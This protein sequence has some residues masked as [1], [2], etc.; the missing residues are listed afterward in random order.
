MEEKRESENG[1]KKFFWCIDCDAARDF[2]AYFLESNP[3]K[4]QAL[5]LKKNKR[6]VRRISVEASLSSKFLYRNDRPNATESK[7]LSV[8]H[9]N[10]AWESSHF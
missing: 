9:E 10:E 2:P 8:V 1:E 6:R 5:N 7:G 3:N 4:L